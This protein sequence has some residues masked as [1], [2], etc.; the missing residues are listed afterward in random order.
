MT[1]ILNTEVKMAKT[2]TLLY[3]TWKNKTIFTKLIYKIR[4]YLQTLQN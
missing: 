1:N 3:Q 2:K 4:P